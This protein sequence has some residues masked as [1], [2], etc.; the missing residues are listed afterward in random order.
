MCS[1]CN[2]RNTTHIWYSW[3]M[4]IIHIYIGWNLIFFL[5]LVAASKFSVFLFLPGLTFSNLK[6]PTW[7]ITASS[8][9]AWENYGLF[10]VICYLCRVMQCLGALVSN[11][12]RWVWGESGVGLPLLE[13]EKKGKRL[14]LA[15]FC[16]Y[17]L[18]FWITIYQ[19]ATVKVWLV[20]FII[21]II[22][23]AEEA[24]LSCHKVILT[25]YCLN[26]I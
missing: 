4:S 23:C 20:I 17:F 12:T 3:N 8:L 9:H 13:G 15:P 6:T 2:K 10:I 26:I 19:S 22:P 1:N 14:I 18:G 11:R 5:P 24:F 21:K 16:P 7:S 25:F